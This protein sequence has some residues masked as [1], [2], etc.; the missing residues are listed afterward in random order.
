LFFFR[1]QIAFS[2]GERQQ[3]ELIR[4]LFNGAKIII[5]DELTSAFSLEQKKMMFQTLKNSL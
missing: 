5:L 4:L 1:E 3:V 2:I